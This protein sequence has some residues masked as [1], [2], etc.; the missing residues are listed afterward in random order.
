MDS[1]ISWTVL[2]MWVGRFGCSCGPFLILP[3]ADLAVS[4]FRHI[5]NLWAVLVRAV[6]VYGPFWYRPVLFI[7]SFWLLAKLWKR[8]LVV[9]QLLVHRTTCFGED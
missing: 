6:L 1:F 5:E 8:I 7:V 4:R 3:W 2:D 9:L